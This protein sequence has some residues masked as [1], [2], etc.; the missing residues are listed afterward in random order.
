MASFPSAFL[1]NREWQQPPEP[2]HSM[3]LAA[4]AQYAA[5]A[6]Q[7]WAEYKQ[8]HHRQSS[9]TTCSPSNSSF[10]GP[11]LPG[12]SW[13]SDSLALVDLTE[14]NQSMYAT[15]HLSLGTVLVRAKGISTADHRVEPL[16]FFNELVAIIANGDAFAARLLDRITNHLCPLDNDVCDAVAAAD[17]ILGDAEFQGNLFAILDQKGARSETMT[18]A[19]LLRCAVKCD[20]NC[21]YEGLF[22]IA[23]KF[24]NSCYPNCVAYFETHTQTMVVRTTSYVSAGSELN[25]VYLPEETLYRPTNQRR[26]VLAQ[27]Y[28]FTCQ[29]IRCNPLITPKLAGVTPLQLLKRQRYERLLEALRCPRCT[30]GNDAG[31]TCMNSMCIPIDDHRHTDSLDTAP[32]KGWHTCTTCKQIPSIDLHSVLATC[33]TQ[34]DAIV[35]LATGGALPSNLDRDQVKQILDLI[36]RTTEHCNDKMHIGHWLSCRLHVA[37]YT[38]THTLSIRCQKYATLNGLYARAVNM[39]AI[40]TRIAIMAWSPII[41]STCTFMGQLLRRASEAITVEAFLLE[42]NDETAVQEERKELEQEAMEYG[43][44]SHYILMVCGGGEN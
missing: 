38:L 22:P 4:L 21:F 20:R 8:L 5:A 17:P 24:N 27:R 12:E 37:A 39:C 13:L 25:V 42:G 30:G 1:T 18:N 33:A 31:G 2:L 28:G 40:H 15:S 23:S 34:V 36:H 29:C 11:L 14:H 7:S 41:S 19:W 9:S 44:Q 3:S 32:L 16:D 43:R 10:P 35:Q 26:G 6:K